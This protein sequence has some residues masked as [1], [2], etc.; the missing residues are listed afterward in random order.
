MRDQQPYCLVLGGGGAKGVYHIGVW[1]ALQELQIPVDAFIG[2]SI[3]AIISAFLAQ[4]AEEQLLQIAKS[5]NLNS[6]IRL[7]KEESL[8]DEE[9]IESKPLKYWQAAYNN[10]VERRGIDTSPMRQMLESALN[11]TEIRESGKDFGITTV[12]VSDFKPREVFIENM[13]S[14]QLLNYVMASAAFPGFERPKIEGKKYIDGGLYDNVPY[15]M[16]RKRGYRRIILVDISGI[17]FS[18]RP[19]PEGS[20]TVYIKNSIDM[21]NAFDFT[22]EFIQQFWLL[23]Y[24]DTLL[25]F[26]ELAGYDYFLVPNEELESSWR[27]K[28]EFTEQLNKNTEAIP[29]QMKHD[30]RKLLMLLESC[31]GLL[32]VERIR[33]YSYLELANE[34]DKAIESTE[35]QATDFIS[36]HGLEPEV[37]PLR[38]LDALTRDVMQSKSLAENPYYYHFLAQKF[39]SNKTVELAEKYLIKATPELQLLDL[40]ITQVKGKLK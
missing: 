14:G 33:K 20:E 34:I 38:L 15:R 35:K 8:A 7:S 24:L 29:E 36:T 25:A 39:S 22:P 32:K 12:N 27:K 26:N 40:Y 2:N 6:L 37:P 21:G 23:G 19:K 4:G 18:R 1:Q 30:R 3:G 5:I 16:A 9:S 31:A 17:G 10:I 28:A 11:E 13:E